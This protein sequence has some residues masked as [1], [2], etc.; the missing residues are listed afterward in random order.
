MKVISVLPRGT[1]AVGDTFKG[2]R[3]WNQR[4]P[5]SSR[6]ELSPYEK[7]RLELASSLVLIDF[8]LTLL[9][10]YGNR[11]QR[12]LNLCPGCDDCAVLF[13]CDILCYRHMTACLRIGWA[14][15]V[16]CTTC[17]L[18][19]SPSPWP[20]DLKIGSPDTPT[21]VIHH[22]TALTK[23][24]KNHCRIYRNAVFAHFVFSAH[25]QPHRSELQLSRRSSKQP[26]RHGEVELL[27][28][29]R[30][31]RLGAAKAV[32]SVAAACVFRRPKEARAR[33]RVCVCA[34][35]TRRW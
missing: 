34:L 18:F 16:P 31:G 14:V 15:C 22:R 3:R 1:T 10:V 7:R 33:T 19:S 17:T 21:R 5:L 25:Q 24:I 23:D 27:E 11:Y 4:P 20:P 28:G 8:E 29:W 2:N 30:G 32:S 9:L 6:R 13:V 26:G 12:F 35:A